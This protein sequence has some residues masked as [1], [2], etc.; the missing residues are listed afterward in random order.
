MTLRHAR[1]RGTQNSLSDS[2]ANHAQGNVEAASKLRRLCSSCC[3]ADWC[4]RAKLLRKCGKRRFKQECEQMSLKAKCTSSTARAVAWR[5][6]RRWVCRHRVFWLRAR[7]QAHPCNQ[8]LLGNVA[9]W[10]HAKWMAAMM[11]NCS[12]LWQCLSSKVC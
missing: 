6:A 1:K 2:V 10:K 7:D 12:C 8:Q 9:E 5:Q 4:A 3:E 11:I